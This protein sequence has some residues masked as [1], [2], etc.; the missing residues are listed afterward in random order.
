M[1]APSPNPLMDG[2]DASSHAQNG[3]QASIA[4]PVNGFSMSGNVFM[5]V[6]TPP[7]NSM[8]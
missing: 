8:I 7:R 2:L 6:G 5:G 3:Q 1:D 4:G